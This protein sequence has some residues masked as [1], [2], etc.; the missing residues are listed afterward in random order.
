MIHRSNF[1]FKMRVVFV[2][3][4]FYAGL[5][6]VRITDI[7]NNIDRALDLYENSR[8]FIDKIRSYFADKPKW[9]NE[10]NKADYFDCRPMNWRVKSLICTDSCDYGQ[11]K[12]MWC[13][14][15]I[16]SGVNKGE[17]GWDYCHCTLRK[18]MKGFILDAKH[19]L[20]EDEPLSDAANER[21]QWWLIAITCAF[22]SI[23][24]L[25]CLS[26]FC[27]DC[28]C[29]ETGYG[30]PDHEAIEIPNHPRSTP[31]ENTLTDEAE[32]TPV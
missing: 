12:Y 25:C 3:C 28:C 5:H 7:T 27:C 24:F 8:D 6:A 31:S 21:W 10:W 19:S 1:K 20:M 16:E 22:T 17:R 23:I 30:G 14:T 15:R 32:D 11:E 29:N 4:V 2:F 9:L 26:K 18:G 13:N